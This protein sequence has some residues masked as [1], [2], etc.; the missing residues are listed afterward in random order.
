MA[1]ESISVV[2]LVQTIIKASIELFGRFSSTTICSA[3]DQQSCP[4]TIQYYVVVICSSTVGIKILTGPRKSAAAEPFWASQVVLRDACGNTLRT[5]KVNFKA[6][7]NNS[8][9]SSSNH[10]YYYRYCSVQCSLFSIKKGAKN[11]GSL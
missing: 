9:N 8:C 5:L 7:S 1:G 3:V 4:F 2:A 11:I 6:M 10:H